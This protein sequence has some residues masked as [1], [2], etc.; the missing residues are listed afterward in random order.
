MPERELRCKGNKLHGLIV[1]QYADGVIEVRCGSKF[2]GKEPGVIVLHRFDLSSG[3]ME[4]RRYLDPAKHSKD[5]D[6]A[7]PHPSTPLRIA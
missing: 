5:G 7:E 1:S 6:N 4:T 3:E 2:C